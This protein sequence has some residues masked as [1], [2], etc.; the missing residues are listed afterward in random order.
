M[1]QK[2]WESPVMEFRYGLWT[3]IS[4]IFGEDGRQLG[5]NNTRPLVFNEHIPA[6]TVACKYKGSRHGKLINMSALRVAM[7]NFYETTTIAVA[8]LDFHMRQQQLAQSDIPGIWDLYAISRASLALIAYRYR[9]D[10]RPTDELL[11]NDLA[12]QYKLITGVFMICREMTNQNHVSTLNNGAVTAQ[13]LY[14]FADDNKIFY[15]PSE[16]V[17]AGS[18][19]KIIEFLEFVIKGR[20]HPDSEKL[21]FKRQEDVLSVL[22]GLVSDIDGWYR[23]ALLTVELDNYI[24]LEI[25]R[26][27]MNGGDSDKIRLQ[28]VYDGYSAQHRYWKSCLADSDQFTESNFKQGV[29]VRQNNILSAIGRPNIR[30]IPDKLIDARLAHSSDY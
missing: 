18:T 2:P 1:L 11:Q 21:H 28:P 23:Y 3:G 27:K 4:P 16:M 24:E 30:R 26:R 14:D 8:V 9:A 29:L 20:N 19:L 12:S 5:E 6:E 7:K 15:S 25:L 13:Q 17:C 22:G 10:D